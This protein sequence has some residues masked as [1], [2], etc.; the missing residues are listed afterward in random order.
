MKP[1]PPTD[2]YELVLRLR[3]GDHRAFEMI[4]HRYAKRVAA[5]LLK[6][7]RSRE[8][9]EDLLQDTFTKIWAVRDTIKPNH[10]FPAFVFT[11]AANL[12]SNSVRKHLRDSYMQTQ[13]KTTIR[14]GYVHIEENL[15]AAEERDWMQQALAQLAPRQRQVFI[16]HKLEGKSYKEISEQ[17][18]ISPSAINHLIQRANKKMA[19]LISS[20]LM[21]TLSLLSSFL[22]R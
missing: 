11:I 17:L 21:L 18:S 22:H 10:S 4:Y 19:T 5:T 14:E 6:I 8:A 13:L 2:D 1:V 12:A 9:A 16:M 3:A 7:T 20:K 15:I